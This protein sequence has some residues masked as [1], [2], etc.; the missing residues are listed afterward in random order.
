M[1]T[2]FLIVL[3]TILDFHVRGLF[4][5]TRIVPSQHAYIKRKSTETALEHGQYT[6]VPF[7]DI[8]GALKNANKVSVRKLRKLGANEDV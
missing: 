8:E 6:L 4:D 1:V 5:S 3:K 2:T 7:L